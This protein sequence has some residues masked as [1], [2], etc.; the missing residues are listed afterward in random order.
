MG[1]GNVGSSILSSSTLNKKTAQSSTSATASGGSST[2]SGSTKKKDEPTKEEKQAYKNQEAITNYDTNAAVQEYNSQMQGYDQADKQAASMYRRG[3]Y[4]NKQQS[5]GD[6]FNQQAKLQRS[7]Q[8]LNDSLGTAGYSSTMLDYMDAVERQDDQ[9]DRESLNQQRENQNNLSRDYW[10]TMQTNQS[11]RQQALTNLNKELDTITSSWLA[12][13]NN[14]NPMLLKDSGAI[15]GKSVTEAKLPK[16]LVNAL[17]KYTT[18]ESKNT[19]ENRKL[20]GFQSTSVKTA[21][22]NL[23]KAN[24]TL[25]K[26]TKTYNKAAAK[27][28]TAKTKY[29]AAKK[30]YND[31]V[32]KAK[33]DGKI[34]KA[35]Q[36]KID[37]LK[38][39]MSTA[40]KKASTTKKTLTKAKTTYKSS[41]TAASDSQKKLTQ[42]QGAKKKYSSI[43]SKN[44]SY[45][46]PVKVTNAKLPSTGSAGDKAVFFRNDNAIRKADQTNTPVKSSTYPTASANSDYWTRIRA[47]YSSRDQ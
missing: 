31:Y 22:K 19:L 32:K 20:L 18:D 4:Q 12:N 38:K 7:V 23:A 5:T 41:K 45:N 16:N 21:E 14:I 8:S 47:G 6:W 27:Y 30:S 28:D 2:G 17:L 46:T 43:I 35:E 37:A 24:S 36:K 34:T 42:A 10:S 1:T 33:K 9:I 29:N 3:T 13:A 44:Q 40:K 15:K 11:N 39:T 25:A 26:D